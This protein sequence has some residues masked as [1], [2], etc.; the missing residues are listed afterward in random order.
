MSV[1]H[2]IKSFFYPERCPYC[3]KIIEPEAVACERCLKTLEQKQRPIVRGAMGY[4]CVSSFIYAGSVRRALI[5][6]KFRDRTQFIRP[7][8]AILAK[9]ILSSFAEY[10]FDA[11]TYV[12]MHPKDQRRRGF[13]QS[14]LLAGELSRLLGVELIHAL[15]K[16]KRTKAQHTLTYQ[17]RKKNLS[18]AF[19][20]TDRESVKGKAILLIDDII[21]S[22]NTLGTCCKKLNTAK[23]SLICCA[24]VAD[25]GTQYEKDAVI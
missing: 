11:V 16:V 9:D 18:G 10:T 5:L 2:H 8:A 6:V 13:N 14:E 25:A 22:G 20:L 7:L 21:T 12:P 1:L 4:R 24:A 19:S 15:T 3:F 17:E 23:P